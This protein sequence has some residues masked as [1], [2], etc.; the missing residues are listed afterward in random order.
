MSMSASVQDYIA[1]QP[2]LSWRRRMLRGLIRGIGFGLLWRVTVTGAENIPNSGPAIIMMNHTAMID[3][4][5]CMGAIMN[6][7][8]IPMSK[9]ENMRNPLIRPFILWWGAYLVHRG[10]VD[11]KALVNSIELVKSGQLILIAPEGHRQTNGLAEAKDG[12][13]YVATKTGAA[14]IP[15]AISGAQ[16]WEKKLKRLQRPHIHINFGRAFRFKTD[17]AARVP[18]ETLAEM[19]HEAMYQLA[20]ALADPSARGVYSDVSK[21]TTNHLQFL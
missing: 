3:P 18:R 6:R 1:V 7:F 21:A 14:I 10:E 20:L 13:A 15:T 17:G 11:R 12:L 8:V 2:R 4:V 5:L 9:A 19:S 16:G